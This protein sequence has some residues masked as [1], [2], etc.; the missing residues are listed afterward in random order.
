MKSWGLR[1]SCTTMVKFCSSEPTAEFWFLSPI[2]WS[3]KRWFTS[4]ECDTFGVL[5]F[6]S[7]NLCIQSQR[8]NTPPTIRF[9]SW[10][11][12]YDSIHTT[13]SATQFMLQ[14]WR[15]DSRYQLD[16]WIHDTEFMTQFIVPAS[17]VNSRHNVQ[18]VHNTCLT[19]WFTTLAWI[20]SWY[21]VHNLIHNSDLTIRTTTQDSW[22]YSPYWLDDSCS[23]CCHN[24]G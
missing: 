10:S 16:N 17:R 22:F 24:T 14:A 19:N 23:A 3:L 7:P 8:C 11:W 4:E 12:V 2:S 9:D 20:I 21:R 18:S 13:G 6:F 15:F 5:F 1:T